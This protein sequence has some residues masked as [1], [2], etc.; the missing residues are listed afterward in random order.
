MGMND[1]INN[2]IRDRQESDA[3]IASG[4]A[5]ST[6]QA[7]AIIEEEREL[8]AWYESATPARKLAF[9]RVIRERAG[10]IGRGHKSRV[11]INWA[12]DVDPDGDECHWWYAGR[13]YYWT[14]P[15]GK[16]IVRHPNAYKWPT[17]YHASTRHLVCSRSLALD[18][19]RALKEHG[20]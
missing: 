3:L 18:T 13:S 10:E 2:I 16:T 11:A 12:G 14:T 19:I 5:T 17:V 15:S 7:R 6:Y 8:R 1:A 20:K 9:D 4:D